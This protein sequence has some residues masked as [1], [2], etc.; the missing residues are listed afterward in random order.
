MTEQIETRVSRILNPSDISLVFPKELSFFQPYLPYFVQETLGI[1]GDVYIA[2]D[3][4]KTISGL[5]IYDDSEKEG[6]IFTGSREVYDRFYA[7][8]PSDSIFAE[9]KT[10]Q[11]CETYDIY[12]SDLEN[13]PLNHR[14]SHEIS[15]AEKD[16]LDEVERFMLLANPRMNRKW[17]TV[18]FQDGDNCFI[19]RIGENIAGLGWL[20]LVNG[21]GRLH[22]LH[23]KPEFRNIG[24]GKDLLFARLLW[25]KSRK[26]RS[27]FSEI[28]RY[29]VPS[30]RIAIRGQ[31]RASGQIF[32]YFRKS[33]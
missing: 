27:A 32:Q 1:G 2:W 25:L 20:S 31:M 24:I 4:D 26:A 21:L 3:R 33:T 5:F 30:A 12:T 22:S 11:D 19:A 23:V 17:M 9:L 18:A 8:R 15:I 13:V 16:Q 28:S 7:L 29:N 6:A 10:E 14:F